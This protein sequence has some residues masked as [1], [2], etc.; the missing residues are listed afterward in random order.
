VY[1]ALLVSAGVLASLGIKL[2]TQIPM[3]EVARREML[4]LIK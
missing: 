3:F 2:V 4:E 1:A